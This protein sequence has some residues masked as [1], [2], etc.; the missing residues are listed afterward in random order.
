MTD[1]DLKAAKEFIDEA[2]ENWVKEDESEA[3]SKIVFSINRIIKH[4]HA[5][6]GSTQ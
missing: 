5:S 1:V 2:W 4:L 6:G 3:I